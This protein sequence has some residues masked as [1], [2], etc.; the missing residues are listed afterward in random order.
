MPREAGAGGAGVLLAVEVEDGLAQT[1]V[2]RRPGVGPRQVAREE[3]LRRPLTDAR[4]GDERGLDLLVG[5]D[6]QRVEVELGRARPMTYSALR[7]EN[8]SATS[9]PDRASARR[10]RVGNA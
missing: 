6:G 4:K 9:S 10:S 5:Q 7:R 1:E 3:P 2:A 8:P